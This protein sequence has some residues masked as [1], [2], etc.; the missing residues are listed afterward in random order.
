MDAMEGLV[1]L[2]IGV[3]DRVVLLGGNLR[4]TCFIGVLVVVVEEDEALL[5]MF[6]RVAILV[7]GAFAAGDFECINWCVGIEVFAIVALGIDIV[8]GNLGA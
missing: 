7:G 8:E 5:V 2:D 1:G 4:S 3:D 6:G